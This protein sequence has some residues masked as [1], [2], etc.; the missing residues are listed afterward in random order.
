MPTGIDVYA[1]YKADTEAKHPQY[2]DEMV[3]EYRE[4]Q[5][6]MAAEM[7]VDYR[8]YYSDEY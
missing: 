2:S 8:E 7:V 4:Y 1:G 3:A 5:D 6:E